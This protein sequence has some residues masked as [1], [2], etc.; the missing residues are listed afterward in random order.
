ML[1]GRRCAPHP[2]SRFGAQCGGLPRVARGAT[3]PLV[4]PSLSETTS[5]SATCPHGGSF[6]RSRA[7]SAPLEGPATRASAR[8][9]VTTFASAVEAC[10]TVWPRCQTFLYKYMALQLCQQ[11][12]RGVPRARPVIKPE[13]PPIPAGLGSRFRYLE[14]N[15]SVTRRRPGLVT[16]A[17][18]GSNASIQLVWILVSPDG[19]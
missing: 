8:T 5:A 11:G 19:R 2:S 13:S 15:L 14:K 10:V 18:G 17:T 7:V 12:R 4:P 9:R 1:E 16:S 6:P 3:A